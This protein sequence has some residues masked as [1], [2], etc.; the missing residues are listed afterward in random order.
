MR[1]TIEATSE[2]PSTSLS[3]VLHAASLLVI[4]AEPAV[5]FDSL[6]QVC[7]PLVCDAAAA[8]ISELDGGMHAARWSARAADDRLQPES[9]VT[10]FSAPASGDHA[11]YHGIISLRFRCQEE[12]APLIAQLFVQRAMANVERARFAASAARHKAT[13]DHLELN[14]SS[15]REIGIAVG[16]LMVKQKITDEQAF[17]LLSRVSQRSNR[18]LRLIALEVAR[19]GVIALP[20]GLATIEPGSRRRRRRRVSVP[21]PGLR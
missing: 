2:E 17:D 5:V 21:A 9:L 20:Q 7:A 6:V 12:A 11:G 10:D 4:S 13:A 3:R 15:N 1:T 14:R 8:T 16:I 18:S 19:T